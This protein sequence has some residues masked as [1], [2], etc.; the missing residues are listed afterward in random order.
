MGPL[1]HR[2]SPAPLPAP[3]SSGTPLALDWF[4]PFC[5]RGCT[6]Q[7]GTV[8]Q[9]VACA[10][11]PY[12]Q[13][14][15]MPFAQCKLIYRWAATLYQNRTLMQLADAMPADEPGAGG[16]EYYTYGLT[17]AA[18]ADLVYP[19]VGGPTGYLSWRQ[20]PGAAA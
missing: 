20:L 1:S 10:H 4:L 9:Q 13:I 7:T 6:Q 5:S 14:E 3:A 11:W 2:P 12:M 19:D 8:K 15:T 18:W 16:A 17:A